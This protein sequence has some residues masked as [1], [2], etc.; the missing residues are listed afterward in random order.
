V[1]VKLIR[2]SKKRSTV[3]CGACLSII[4][5]VCLYLVPGFI[6]FLAI[7]AGLFTTIEGWD[8]MDSLYFAF[9]TLT[10]VGF[11]DFIAGVTYVGDWTWLYRLFVVVWMFF[12]LAYLVMV[13]NIIT[14]GLRSRPVIKL[15]KKMASHIRATRVKLAKDARLLRNLVNEIKIIKIKPVYR[16]EKNDI[17]PVHIGS[18]DFYLHLNSPESSDSALRAL[19]DSSSE[20]ALD[21][22][23]RCAT[24]H[25]QINQ[26]TRIKSFEERHGDEDPLELL[27][28]IVTLLCEDTAELAA[29]DEDNLDE[30]EEKLEMADMHN[31]DALQTAKRKS[32]VAKCTT[33]NERGNQPT[34]Q[35]KSSTRKRSFSPPF[36]ILRRQS[37]KLH[38][39]VTMGQK[40]NG[41]QRSASESRS[42]PYQR[43]VNMQPGATDPRCKC[44]VARR[45]SEMS[46]PRSIDGCE[47]RKLSAKTVE[48]C[49]VLDNLQEVKL[50]RQE[51]SSESS[52]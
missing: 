52:I 41:H 38:G 25:Q 15:E 43:Q 47:Q 8:Y 21:E 11:G 1:C 13:I 29:T 18:T 39:K 50:N 45:H 37:G 49:K 33:V 51:G 14:Q 28:R 48:F 31:A 46:P 35:K 40:V 24:F 10:T 26:S 12:G 4:L 6:V 42:A 23:D 27:T 7:P 34:N 30:D 20:S 22:I 36:S 44:V 17:R 5:D 3:R 9:I 2:K 32:L 19:K 16:S